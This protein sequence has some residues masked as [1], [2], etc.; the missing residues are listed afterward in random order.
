MLQVAHVVSK[1]QEGLATVGKV[2]SKEETRHHSADHVNMKL[3]HN[4]KVINET[5]CEK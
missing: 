1:T 2:L 4:Q 5:K 3:V